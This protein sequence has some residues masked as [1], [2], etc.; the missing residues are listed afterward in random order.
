MELFKDGNKKQEREK[1]EPLQFQLM[2]LE[3]K[4]ETSHACVCVLQCFNIIFDE[5]YIVGHICPRSLNP[6]G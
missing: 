5:Q 1:G 6:K 2:N 3:Y 4:G